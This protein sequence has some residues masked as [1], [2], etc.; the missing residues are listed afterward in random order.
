MRAWVRHT[1]TGAYAPRASVAFRA[2]AWTP[3]VP[4]R[5]PHAV[6]AFATGKGGDADDVAAGTGPRGNGERRDVENGEG[7]AGTQGARSERVPGDSDREALG[8]TPRGPRSDD[9]LGAGDPRTPP[10]AEPGA[11]DL[12]TP[13]PPPPPPAPTPPPAPDPHEVQRAAPPAHELVDPHSTSLFRNYPRSLRSLALKA[14][15]FAGARTEEGSQ[16]RANAARG[17]PTQEELLRIARGF[18]TRLRIRFKWVTIRGFRR[19]NADEISAFFT[20]GGLGTAIWIIVGT[21]TFVSVVFVALRLLNL[22]EWIALQLA[23]YISAQVGMTVVCGSAIVPKW[24]EGRLSIKD[25]VV[26][27]RAEY[28]DPE[29]LQHERQA[30]DSTDADAHAH[31]DDAHAEWDGIPSFDT[32]KHVVPPMCEAARDEQRRDRNFSMFEL[33]IDSVDVQVSLSRWLDGHGII[34][35]ADVRGVRGIVDRRNVFWD[36]DVPYDPRAARRRPRPGDFDLELFTVE[37]LLV[38]VYQPGDFRPFNVSVFTARVPR[39][40]TQWLFFDLLN[41]DS[42]TGQLD[43]CLF[44]LHKPQSVRHTMRA[45]YGKQPAPHFQNWSR[46]RIDGVNIDH[47]QKMAGLQGPLMWIYSGRFD[48][49][50]DVKFP[51]QYGEDVDINAIISEMLDSLTMAFTREGRGRRDDDD[52]VIPGQPMLSEPAIFAPVAAVGPVSERAR[53]RQEEHDQAEQQTRRSPRGQR[54]GGAAAST[55]SHLEL[56]EGDKMIPPSVVI[57]VDLRFKDIKASMPIFTRELSYSSYAFA[58]PVVAFMN[59]NK[60]LIPINCRIVMDLSEFDGS[61]DLPQ[62]GLPPL[63]S[64]KIYEAMAFHVQSKQA[65]SERAR[66]VSLWTLSLAKQGLLKLARHLR[67][68]LARTVPQT[69]AI[70]WGGGKAAVE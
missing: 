28:V 31:G 2:R 13:A 60:T 11:D 19:F 55:L 69:D 4:G 30:Q 51:R 40:R 49:V 3:A 44:S 7:A 14:R 67:D 35:A 68:L 8:A 63:I 20:L 5:Y 59:A 25:V 46:L 16:A 39:L 38:T 58:R 52:M 64:E 33:R 6:R 70:A 61:L 50:A 26:T 66:N 24:K 41:A 10:P 17:T 43:G 32:G 29:A 1:R 12:H 18:W 57:E 62:T 9:E 48:L 47:L 23:K 45:V 36:P 65:N 53:R 34:Q 37:D 27:R 54:D 15:N 42:I 56:G 21:T 22:Q